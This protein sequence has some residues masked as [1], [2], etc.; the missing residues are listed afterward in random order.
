M[1]ICS[2][3]IFRIFT[4]RSKKL[5]N[6]Y[7]ILVTGL[8]TIY[9]LSR[10]IYNAKYDKPDP[11]Y[12]FNQPDQLKLL[13]QFLHKVN[14]NRR[15]CYQ[16]L[17]RPPNANVDILNDISNAEVEPE[18]GASIFFLMTSCSKSGLIKFSTR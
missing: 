10:V 18:T 7:L 16:F 12:R 3:T 14:P 2:I 1:F 17:N 11:S 9:T 13:D 8:L 5:R 4:M 15:D 6:Y